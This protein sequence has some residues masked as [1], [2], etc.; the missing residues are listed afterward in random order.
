MSARILPAARRRRHVELA[1]CRQDPVAFIE[2]VGDITLDPVQVEWVRFWEANEASVLHAGVGLGKTSLARFFVLWLVG[3]K[4]TAQLIWLGATQ[5]QP[6]QQ[7]ATISRLIET[8]G[9]RSRLHHVFPKLRPGPIW[10]STEIEVE[11]VMTGLDSSPTIQVFGA[12][13]ESVLGSRATIL[14]IDDL[15][16]FNNTLTEEGRSKMIEWLS[17]V[18]SRLTK[19]DVRIMVLGNFWHRQDALMDLHNNKGF[20]YRKTPAFIRDP[21]A[22]DDPK[23]WTMTCP[24]ALSSKAAVKL[25]QRLGPR[26]SRQMLECEVPDL[27]LGRFKELWFEAALTAG[28]G[29]PFAPP[30]VHYPAF[31]G[32]DLGHTKK[33]GADR[34]A[35]VT[36]ILPPG[37]RKQIIDV[38]SGTWSSA[39]ITA[40]LAE[41][42]ARYNSTIG[43]E[44]NGGQN[45]WMDSIR[46]MTAI[47]LIDH[48]T[49]QYNKRH[50]ANGVEG[51]AIALSQGGWVFPCPP[52]PKLHAQGMLE[53]GE[54]RG[55]AHEEIQALIAEALSFDPTKP[56]EH[57]GDRL[58]A[59]WILSEVIRKSSLK[60]YDDAVLPAIDV[61][62]LDLF[63]R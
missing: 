35:M 57:V 32:V 24:A 21:E 19:D 50:L 42:R 30:R 11:R 56:R 4:P 12:Y 29:R 8:R 60:A 51:L 26:K 49:N 5:R 63:S 17:T 52:R 25:A 59:W 3:N 54:G 44:N 20:V 9:V 58:M 13:S 23:R 38:R 53:A 31:T 48:N 22:P 7:L 15:C 2:Y 14:V 47:P 28:L 46:D 41:L 62:D 61:P 27:N 40:N 16:N 36:A 55:Q 6:K 43:V 34:T 33:P 1:R 18:L 10:R 45:L 39:Q 37:G